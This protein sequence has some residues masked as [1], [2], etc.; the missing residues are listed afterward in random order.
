LSCRAPVRGGADGTER[1]ATALFF[2][3]IDG[4]EQ[5]I[6]ADQDGEAAATPE[7]SSSTEAAPPIDSSPSG[8]ATESLGRPDT[9]AAENTITAVV[10][11]D[12]YMPTER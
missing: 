2:E 8:T 3:Y 7:A 1:S 5:F 9:F 11:S 6:G 12:R 4:V 10:R